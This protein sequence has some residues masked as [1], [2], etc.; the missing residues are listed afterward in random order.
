MQERVVAV[1]DAEVL[2][3]EPVEAGE[4]GVPGEGEPGDEDAQRQERRDAVERDEHHGVTLRGAKSAVC[5][6]PLK[7]RSAGGGA[8]GLRARGYGEPA[9]PRSQYPPWL[10][11]SV[12]GLGE[13]RKPA[14]G[15]S[16]G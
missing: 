14:G 7:A 10:F 4:G 3:D 12:Y 2:E 9:L 5:C 15:S 6:P 13:G 8:K 11:S 1:E 16:T